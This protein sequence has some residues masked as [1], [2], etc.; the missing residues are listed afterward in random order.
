MK[1]D[2]GIRAHGY[3]SRCTI[4]PVKGIRK[5]AKFD[6]FLSVRGNLDC[7]GESES[8]RRYVCGMSGKQN[9][10]RRT[11]K[12]ELLCVCSVFDRW[13]SNPR[14]PGDPEAGTWGSGD[15]RENLEMENGTSW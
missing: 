13:V 15:Q 14:H 8:G 3:C 7:R 5:D 6:V 11:G 9:T 4:H 10:R 2:R 12:R 1:K